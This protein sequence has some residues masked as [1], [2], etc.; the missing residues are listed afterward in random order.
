MDS[1]GFSCYEG[2]FSC[3]RTT[4]AGLLCAV[5]DTLGKFWRRETYGIFAFPDRC[6]R[7]QC[8]KSSPQI[9]V[10]LLISV[11]LVQWLSYKVTMKNFIVIVIVLL[12]MAH[13]LQV[14]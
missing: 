10:P 7:S 11:V 2:T 5:R 6:N 1:E 8:N 4:F 13:F 9:W 14:L 12:A 3:C